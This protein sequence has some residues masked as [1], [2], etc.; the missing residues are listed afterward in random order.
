MTSFGVIIFPTDYSIRP[1]T[2]A[3]AAE[4]RGFD[5]V[6]FPEHTHIPTSRKTPFPMGGDL[7]REYSHA[8]DLMIAMTAAAMVTSR[9]KIGSGVCLMTEHDPIHLAKQVASLDVLSQG[10]VILGIGAGWNAEEME[11]HGVAFKKRWRVTGERV[12]AM[13]Q[14]WTNEAAEFHGETVN[15]DPIW[16]WPKPAQAGGPPVWMGSLSMKS[17]ERV[18][19]YCDGWFPVDSPAEA[20]ARRLELL[21]QAADRAGRR[22][23]TIALGAGV[24]GAT[25][26]KCQRLIDLGFTHLVLGQPSF[27]E[28]K[29]LQRLDQTAELVA[30]LR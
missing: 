22:F 25:A 4:E 19:E 6:F 7:P 10:R 18:V 13:K 8:H 11:H 9:V 26:D 12:K 28:H 1:D 21:R 17:L 16:C 23:D 27:E 24:F 20:L 15:F 29:A 3:A 30:K 2:F 14:I 5:S